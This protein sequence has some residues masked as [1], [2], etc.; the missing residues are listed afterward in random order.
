MAEEAAAA[1]PEAAAKGGMGKL[2]V[3]GGAVIALGGGGVAAWTLGFIPHGSKTEAPAS[4]EGMP[5][6]EK[7]GVGAIVPLDPFIANLA[8]EDGK[9]YLKA[10]LQV[11]FFTAKEPEDFK[12]PQIR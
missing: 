6:E 1:A 5:K 10:T 12:T 4:S 2:L 3:I 9:R 11:E 8:D 7:S